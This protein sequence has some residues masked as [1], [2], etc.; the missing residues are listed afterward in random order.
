MATY[1]GMVTPPTPGR[2]AKPD[3][4]PALAVVLMAALW[5]YSWIAIKL[6]AGEASPFVI[7]VIRVSVAA[8]GL[9]ACLLVTGK[10]LRPTPM[11]PTFTSGMLQL[12]LFVT[13]QNLAIISGGVGKTA[14]LTYT[15]PLWV[16][17][18]APMTLGERITPQR[19]LA[20]FLGLGG[21]ACTLTPFDLTHDPLSKGLALATAVVW[22]AGVVATKRFRTRTQVDTLQ[23]TAWQ[24]VY[25]IPPLAL[26]AILVPGEYLHPSLRFFGLMAYVAIG[27]TTFAFLLFM[28][29]VA[30]LSA[31]AAG[32]AS[33]STPVVST[34]LAV[35]LLA[36]RPT[37]IEITGMVLIVAALAVNSLPLRAFTR[38]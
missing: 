34:A 27:G 30:R 3:L 37:P 11:W 20:L 10:S 2:S 12:G 26:A 7:A 29:V 23:F 24:M 15:M 18:M 6:V 35:V 4:L 13:L 17:L 16:V 25:S 14:I 38:R 9:F 21:L 5:G 8:L 22:A 36:E 31:G 32:I 28:F 19:G 33:L 1:T